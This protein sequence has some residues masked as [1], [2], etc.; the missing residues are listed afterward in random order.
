M[1]VCLKAIK[2]VTTLAATLAP[3]VLESDFE[4]SN[5]AHAGADSRSC[6]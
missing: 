1:N 5:C 4:E 2:A 6:R 3:L